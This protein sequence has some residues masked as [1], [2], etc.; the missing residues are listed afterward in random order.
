M[1]PAVALIVSKVLQPLKCD[2]HIYSITVKPMFN[3]H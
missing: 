3:G 2:Y 1:L